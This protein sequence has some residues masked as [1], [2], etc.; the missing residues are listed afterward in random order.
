MRPQRVA[1]S[2]VLL[3]VLAACA[4][5]PAPVQAWKALDTTAVT[6]DAAMQAAG[7]FY[8]AGK[9]NDAQRDEIIRI[10]GIY[11]LSARAASSI[12]RAWSILSPQATDTPPKV[13]KALADVAQ[14]AADV[15]LATKLYGVTK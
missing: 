8:R 1:L 2:L 3:A 4:A 6:V 9:L 11:Q 10:H 12:I 7:D 15:S 13:Q 14:K 5:A